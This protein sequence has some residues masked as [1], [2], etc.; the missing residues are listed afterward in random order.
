[1]GKL[2]KDTD[3]GRAHASLYNNAKARL[4][5]ATTRDAEWLIAKSTTSY[6]PRRNHKASARGEIR[7]GSDLDMAESLIRD[8]RTA[9]YFQATQV[10]NLT[11]EESG[12]P[13]A[14]WLAIS[15]AQGHIPRDFAK[16]NEES[17]NR[18]YPIASAKEWRDFR[19]ARIIAE[20]IDAAARRNSGYEEA[21]K[22]A[23]AFI[24]AGGLDNLNTEAKQLKA[25]NAAIRQAHKEHTM[26]TAKPIASRAL[27]CP[28][29]ADDE[30]AP[31]TGEMADYT[32]QTA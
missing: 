5:L 11:S 30:E 18:T 17:G 6:N 10:L 27:V 31:A 29:E 20:R 22:T 25:I 14:A 1:M 26:E 23:R 15:M 3:E 7:E 13:D 28:I 32:P 9:Q 2:T 19:N 4:K 21:L 8:E 16:V 24:A 12:I